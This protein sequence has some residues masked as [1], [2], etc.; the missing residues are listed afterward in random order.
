M[1]QH[2]Y[3]VMRPGLHAKQKIDGCVQERLHGTV[4]IT[5]DKSPVGGASGE[6]FRDMVKRLNIPVLDDKMFVI[7]KKRAAENDLT[8]QKKSRQKKPGENISPL[9]DRAFIGL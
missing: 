1:N 3:Q 7:E 6:H 9:K 2:Q 5:F 4:K 8:I